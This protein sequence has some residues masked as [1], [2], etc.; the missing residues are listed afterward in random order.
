MIVSDTGCGIAPERI[1][2]IFEPFHSGS[3]GG[4]GL[5]LSIVHR[6]VTEGGG[7]IDVASTPDAGT[8]FFV[9]LPRS[10]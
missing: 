5:G 2:Q 9:D 1:S 4:T 8:K 7:R 10:N 6:L 3:N